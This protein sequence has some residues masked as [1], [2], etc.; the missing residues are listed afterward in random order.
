[1]R[2]IAATVDK[3]LAVTQCGC[4]FTWGQSLSAEREDSLRP[5][6]IEGFGG[7]RVCWVR[8]GDREAFAICEHGELFSWGRGVY[9][10]LGHGDTEN[11]PL[12]KRVE[13]LRGVRVSS[14]S[15]GWS[16]ALALAEDGVVY[17]W[18]ENTRL[19]TMGNPSVA[20]ELLPKPVPALLSVRMVSVEVAGWRSYAVADTGEL[21]AWGIDRDGAR[22]L[23]HGEQT[24]CTL[25][26]P[27]ESLRGV[28]VDAVTAGDGHTLALADEGSVYAW[29][30]A[31]AERTGA[32][33]L[34]QSTEDSASTVPTACVPRR[35]TTLPPLTR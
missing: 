26:K 8:I 6:A 24:D 18:G 19:A 27:I 15:A 9:G 22:P 23:G 5:V 4:V 16:H 32:L 17:A 12:P 33:G 21:W 14:V 35:L 1:V 7:V 29:G 13:A 3:S 31:H 28:K 34:G 25:P 2:G 30:G 11:Q 20:S 10:I